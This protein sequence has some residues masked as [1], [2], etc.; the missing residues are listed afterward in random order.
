MDVLYRYAQSLA[1][2]GSKLVIVSAA[3]QIREQLAVSA[4]L[5]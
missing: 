2:V 5:S 3:A 4:S 1:A